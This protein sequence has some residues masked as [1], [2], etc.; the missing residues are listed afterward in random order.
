MTNPNN[1]VVLALIELT[2]Q[3]QPAES[4]AEVLGAAATVGAP[5]AVVATDSEPAAEVVSSLGELGATQVLAS[6]GA[7]SGYGEAELTALERAIDQSGATT[8]VLSHTITGRNTAGRLAIS[9]HGALAYGTTGLYW[10][11]EGE[12]NVATHAVF[13]GDYNAESTVEGG[14]MIVT[15]RPGSV[16]HRADS[17]SSPELVTLSSG[18]T[19]SKFA[20]VDAVQVAEQTSTRPALTSA[21]IVVSGGRGVGSA[22]NFDLVNQLADAL[23]AGVGASRAAVDSGYVPHS[24]Q[25]GQTGVSVSPTLYVALG[26]SGAIQHLAGMQ[27]AKT[28]VAINKDEEAPIFEV[29]D[30]GVVGDL[31]DVV[32]QL[33]EELGKR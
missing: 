1:P 28:I 11:V 33:I 5:V 30:F 32:P 9:R 16:S 26:I 13:G 4:A 29:A 2:E 22:E 6:T 12:E 24:Y 20:S 31:F 18:E 7:G 19:T 8:V 21:D 27:T 25:V 15:I 14:L 10:D 3:G 23:G 17:V